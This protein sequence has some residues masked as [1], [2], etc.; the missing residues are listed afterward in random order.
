VTEGI[1]AAPNQTTGGDGP[2]AGQLVRIDVLFDAPFDLPAD[3]Y[4]FVPQ[5][6]LATSS[7]VFR[8]LSAPFTGA[9]GDLQMWTRNSDLDPDW[10]R[11]ATDIVGQDPKFNGSFSLYGETID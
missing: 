6:G 1:F 5:V 10:L 9:T 8:W 11:V 7:D 3:H 4:F 2:V